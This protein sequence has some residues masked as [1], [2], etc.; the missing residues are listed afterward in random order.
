MIEYEYDAWGNFT[1]DKK[2]IDGMK[3]E[4][5]LSLVLTIFALTLFLLTL[6]FMHKNNKS[7]QDR[8]VRIILLVCGTFMLFGFYAWLYS[9]K[10]K[11]IISDT[12]VSLTTLFVKKEID[13]CDVEKYTCERYKKSVFYQFT[14]FINGKKLL[15]NTRYKEEFENILKY[16]K[17]EQITK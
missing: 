11:I 2:I 1:M 4:G 8:E 14:L 7:F 6:V 12:H 5:K 3:K 16:N 15:I 13:L 17:I 9:L 10:Y